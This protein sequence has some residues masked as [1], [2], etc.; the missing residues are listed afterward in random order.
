[1]EDS[2]EFQM[3]RIESELG[4]ER[5]C[6][7]TPTKC[8][9]HRVPSKLRKIKE[10][11]YSPC[12]VSIGPLHSTNADLQKMQEYKR[13]YVV[14]LL[15]RTP[16]PEK[17]WNDAK[18]AFH[19]L[20]TTYFECYGSGTNENLFLQ[21]GSF[22]IDCCFILEFFIR[23]SVNDFNY[24]DH[25]NVNNPFMASA[26]ARD[27]LLFE[28]QIP[29]AALRALLDTIENS[30]GERFPNFSLTE[31]VYCFFTS[32]LRLY[33]KPKPIKNCRHLLE[34]FYYNSLSSV[35]VIRWV[36]GDGSFGFKHC[37]TELVEA[38]IEI[39]NDMTSGFLDITF[40]GGVIKFSE[41]RIRDETMVSVFLNLIAYEQCGSTHGVCQQISSYAMLMNSLIRSP[42][43]IDL[44]CQKGIII[45]SRIDNDVTDFFDSICSK[46]VL[47]RFYYPR[48]CEQV[49]AYRDSAEWNRHKLKTSLLARWSRY[50]AA[51]RNDYFSNPWRIISFVAAFIL[52]VL[53]LLQT[54]YA[55]LS[56][57]CSP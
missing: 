5:D 49:N 27:L 55:T 51:L 36:N 15:N 26:V 14:Y 2:R 34:I 37:A 44:L 3:K 57:N 16:Q 46:I 39:Q 45:A 50:K 40:D 30:M 56:Y 43:D 6:R 23:S 17:T 19:H 9:I 28:N 52:L 7:D 47:S 32:S 33:K 41:F 12:M 54:I 35:S 11:A 53:T 18:E 13:H 4:I 48:L 29:F 24:Y 22:L 1:M 10:D 42:K 25:M 21:D 38:G 8:K 31:S 20:E